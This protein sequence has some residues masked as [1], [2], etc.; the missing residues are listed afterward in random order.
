MYLLHQEM[1]NQ[2]ER[3]KCGCFKPLSWKALVGYP[4]SYLKNVLN[5]ASIQS[6]VH[7]CTA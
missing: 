1:K 5:Q 7:L 3:E 2:Y 6:S 4:V